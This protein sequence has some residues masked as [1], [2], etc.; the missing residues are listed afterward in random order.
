MKKFWHPLLVAR[1]LL[2]KR[3][4]S[5]S[6]WFQVDGWISILHHL[7]CSSHLF[8]VFTVTEA[9]APSSFRAVLRYVY[10]L[11]HFC[12]GP[13][14]MR[15]FLSSSFQFL[16][17][18]VFCKLLNPKLIPNNSCWALPIISCLG[19]IKI[20]N[21]TLLVYSTTTRA[22]AIYSQGQQKQFKYLALIRDIELK[23]WG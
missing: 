16:S 17:W 11:T 14:N 20:H 5:S 10:S 22:I 2:Y 8:L 7:F 6:E 21:P 15:G 3:L 19:D 1:S 23:F 9:V 13:F 12:L 4:C 18:C